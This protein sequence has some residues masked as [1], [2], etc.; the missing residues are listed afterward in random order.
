MHK[1]TENEVEFDLNQAK[2]NFMETKKNFVEASTSGIQ[3]KS[4]R[5]SEVQDVDPSLLATF[6]KTCMKLLRDHKAVERLQQMIENC[7]GKNKIPS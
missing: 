2:E 7:M 5:N 6:L 4:A 3:E 1:A